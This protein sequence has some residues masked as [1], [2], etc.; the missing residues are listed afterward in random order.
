[1]TFIVGMEAI[2][3]ST[4]KIGRILVHQRIET[5]EGIEVDNGN[6]PEVACLLDGL[7]IG[8]DILATLVGIIL[9]GLPIGIVGIEPSPM[10]GCEEYNL[11]R[12]ITT[13]HVVETLVDAT[14]IGGVAH[15]GIT[16]TTVYEVLLLVDASHDF[17]WALCEP[18]T[19]G[20][21]SVIVV[22]ADEDE[23]GIDAVAMFCPELIRLLGNIVPL[24]SADAIDV[25]GD[26]QPI[27]KETPV[28]D[29]RT[30]VARIGD[31]VAQI[32]HTLALPGMFDE[33]LRQGRHCQ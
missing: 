27:L 32:G 18:L 21:A 1:M 6:S 30:V 12:W 23:D 8:I 7:H 10:N 16:M 29:L 4:L 33:T 24:A 22:G 19:D 11:L 17:L 25:R 14:A 15:D 26:G 5:A 9:A 2:G 31:G 28:F 3:L 20:N 13:L